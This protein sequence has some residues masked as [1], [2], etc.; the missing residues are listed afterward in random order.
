MKKLFN[1][2]EVLT[3]LEIGSKHLKLVQ[4]AGLAKDKKVYNIIV[5]ELAPSEDGIAQQLKDLAKELQI[6]PNLLT[7]SIS[8]Q[9]AIIRN[10]EFPSTNPAEIKNIVDLQV[11]HTGVSLLLFWMR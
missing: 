4:A 9:F 7:L 1:K 10:L 3:A 2:K 11:L 6:N 5:K 8:H